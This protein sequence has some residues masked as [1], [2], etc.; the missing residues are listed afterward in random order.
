MCEDRDLAKP[1]SG[2]EVGQLPL[3]AS[4]GNSSL[5]EDEELPTTLAFLREPVALR[6]FSFVR[7]DRNLDEFRSCAVREERNP[8]EQVDLLVLAQGHA[9][10]PMACEWA[11]ISLDCQITALVAGGCLGRSLVLRISWLLRLSSNVPCFRVA[12]ESLI[13][14]GLARG[15]RGVVS[16]DRR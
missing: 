15:M 2:A 9:G 5:D 7:A 4:N 3:A 16:G 8:L 1:V 6:G 10:D 14:D 11:G 13:G 12:R